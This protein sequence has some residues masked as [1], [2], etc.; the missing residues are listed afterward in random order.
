MQVTPSPVKGGNTVFTITTKKSTET[1]TIEVSYN[2]VDKTMT[3]V[4]F[5]T[6]PVEVIFAPQNPVIKVDISKEGQV[7]KDYTNAIDSSDE[8]KVDVKQVVSV[9]KEVNPYYEKVHVQII[10][11]E[12]KK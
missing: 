2:T 7:V 10:N 1:Q 12:N 6:K 11:K 8:T 9:E 4:D 3:V 5:T